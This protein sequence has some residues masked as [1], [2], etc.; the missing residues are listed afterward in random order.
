MIVNSSTS[1][2]LEYI[3][4]RAKD[5]YRAYTPGASSN[6]GDVMNHG[7]PPRPSLDPLSAA[8]PEETYFLTTDD[9]G[10]RSY[11]QNGSFHVLNGMI[12]GANGRP[13]LGY[14]TPGSAPADLRIDAVDSALGRVNAVHVEVDGSVAYTRP[15]FDPRTGKREDQ[16]VVVGRLALARF[17]AATKLNAVDA[18]SALAP[19]GIVPHVGAPADGNF[20]ALIPMHQTASHIDIDRSLDR[21][22]DA[23]LAFDALQ[24]AHKAQGAV[25][26]TA[27]DLLK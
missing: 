7:A 13:I 21:L 20:A 10:R 9:R 1:D 17:P 11:T 22:N 12:C 8:P 19:A 5:V 16:R 4:E 24:A 25:S 6:R 14:V 27:M 23:Y 26:K 18:D 15:S 3:S 2:A